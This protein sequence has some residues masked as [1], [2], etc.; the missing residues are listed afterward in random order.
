[1]NYTEFRD[2]MKIEKHF[3]GFDS[4]RPVEWQEKSYNQSRIG[5]VSTVGYGRDG[6]R[7]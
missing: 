2:Q 7:C 1:M 6:K 5:P 3:P 4:R